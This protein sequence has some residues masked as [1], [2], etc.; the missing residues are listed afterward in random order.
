MPHRGNLARSY[1][2]PPLSKQVL[3]G[4]WEAE[5]TSLRRP[6]VLDRLAAAWRLGASASRLD[7]DA[8]RMW[9]SDGSEL[10]F[11]GLVIATGVSPRRFPSFEESLAVQIGGSA[12]DNQELF[13]SLAAWQS[14]LRPL[15]TVGPAV[16]LYI[17]ALRMNILN[18]RCRRTRRW[19]GGQQVEW[20]SPATSVPS[21]RW[22]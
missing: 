19:G 11:D 9:L 3:Q 18:R 8:R 1:D 16:C 17:A 6:D 5:R 13:A 14:R 21:V 2:R 10:L 12:R 4:M 22:L 7:P 15:P 20:K